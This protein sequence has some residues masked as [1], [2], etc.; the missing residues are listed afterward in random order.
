M[1]ALSFLDHGFHL[2]FNIISKNKFKKLMNDL[3]IIR[4]MSTGAHFRGDYRSA[5]YGAFQGPRCAR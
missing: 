4:A 1:I 3:L 2:V 5:F